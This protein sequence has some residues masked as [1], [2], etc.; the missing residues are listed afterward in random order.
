MKR[1]LK[2]ALLFLFVIGITSCATKSADVIAEELQEEIETSDLTEID[3]SIDEQGV[4]IVTNAFL[5]SPESAELT[6]DITNQLDELGAILKNYDDHQIL[7]EGH[8][9]TFGDM[10]FVQ[11]LSEQRAQNIADYLI[12]LHDIKK[13]KTTVVGYG[14]LKPI[15]TN[16]TAEG[17]AKNRRVEITI[18][19]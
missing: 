10:E 7:I 15:A 1:F 9:A 18:M 17:R 13:D 16:D 4:K 11:V 3:V 8:T 6:P 19:N 5:F 14:A 12:S 2:I